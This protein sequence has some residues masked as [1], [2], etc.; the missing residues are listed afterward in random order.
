VSSWYNPE[1]E[2]AGD[3]RG[4][5]EI[6]P[7]RYL[8]VP[9]PK[10]NQLEL[11]LQDSRIQNTDSKLKSMVELAMESPNKYASLRVILQKVPGEWSEGRV[12]KTKRAAGVLC[13]GWKAHDIKPV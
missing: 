10:H 3:L 6:E 11:D 13:A 8:F 7:E 5:L 9:K 12:E 4:E 1:L 2:D